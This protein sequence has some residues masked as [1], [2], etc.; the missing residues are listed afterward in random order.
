MDKEGKMVTTD[1]TD[2]GRKG[3]LAVRGVQGEE[4]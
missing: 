2:G 4:I 3:A 1:L